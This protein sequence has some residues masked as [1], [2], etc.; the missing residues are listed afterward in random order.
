MSKKN[1]KLKMKFNKKLFLR[2]IHLLNS[3][4]LELKIA[5]L[6][7]LTQWKQCMQ[8]GDS[9]DL[10]SSMIMLLNGW[11]PKLDLLLDTKLKG[12]MLG[13][14]VINQGVVWD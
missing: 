1:K 3:M 9:I 2:S 7:E 11:E 14:M 8:C 12:L 6:K 13:W 4:L 10:S 5:S